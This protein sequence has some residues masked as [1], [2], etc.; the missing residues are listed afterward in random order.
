MSYGFQAINQSGYVQIDQNY[1]NF[2]LYSSGSATTGSIVI[3]GVDL[4][5]CL[6]FIRLPLNKWAATDA[7]ASFGDRFVIMPEYGTANFT[8]EYRIYRYS[9]ALSPSTGYSL[10]VFRG[11]GSLCFDGNREQTRIVSASNYTL[12]SGLVTLASVGFNPWILANPLDFVSVQPNPPAFN[13]RWFY[14]G[15]RVN[16]DLTISLKSIQTKI[17]GGVMSVPANTGTT[18]ILFAQ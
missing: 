14:L 13:S 2:A 12:G 7:G 17:T 9:L 11:D 3:A 8:Y 6:V 18:N 15:A 4:A 5:E 1:S 16:G 10:Q